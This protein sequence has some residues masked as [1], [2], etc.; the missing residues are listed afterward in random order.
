MVGDRAEA[1][2]FAGL[3]GPELDCAVII[4]DEHIPAG[5]LQTYLQVRSIINAKKF[6]GLHCLLDDYELLCTLDCETAVMR[7][8]DVRQS[9][10]LRA[11]RRAFAAHCVELPEMRH[12]VHC[13]ARL[14][15][16]STEDRIVREVTDGGRLYAWFENVPTYERDTLGDMFERFGADRDVTVLCDRLSWF[17]FDHIV[18]QYFSCLYRDWHLEDIGWPAPDRPGAWWELWSPKRPED[19]EM[20]AEFAARWAPAWARHPQLLDDVPSAFLC[21]HCDRAIEG[22]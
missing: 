8:G 22:G 21:F 6:I 7:P 17:D 2:K 10:A 12:I 14:F 5:R 16:L 19:R 11:E 3:V 18:Y 15:G 20:A 9:C 1:D 4:A 13:P